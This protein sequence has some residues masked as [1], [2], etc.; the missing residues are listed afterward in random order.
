MDARERKNLSKA[1]EMRS[2]S[3]SLGRKVRCVWAGAGV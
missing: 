3:L 1:T 2:S